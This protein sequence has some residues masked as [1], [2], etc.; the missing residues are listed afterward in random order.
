MGWAPQPPPPWGN[1]LKTFGR[2]AGSA[3]AIVPLD[4]VSLLDAARAATGL[5]DF[6]DAGDD[7]WREAFGRFVR[8]LEEEGD[9]HLLGRIMARN[10]I[11]RAL[12]NRLEVRA[13]LAA[14]P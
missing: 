2:P 3:A 9:L 13:T 10:E 8:A 12:I 14:H 4:E 1:E 7:R 6:G 11:V 5:D